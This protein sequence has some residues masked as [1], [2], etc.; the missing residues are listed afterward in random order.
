MSMGNSD[1]SSSMVLCVQLA[2]TYLEDK[3]VFEEAEKIFDF[4][5]VRKKETKSDSWQ[6]E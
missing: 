4:V 1:I 3:E 2:Q 6:S 5:N